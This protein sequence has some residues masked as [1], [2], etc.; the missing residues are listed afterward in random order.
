MNA[1]IKNIWRKKSWSI[2]ELLGSKSEYT[3]IIIGLIGQLENKNANVIDD[4]PKIEGI[5]NPRTWRE[6]APFLKGLG[7]VKNQNGCLYLS[8]TGEWLNKNLSLYNIASVMQDRFRVFGEILYILD[9]ESGTVQEVNKKICDL[10]KINWNNCSNTRK[11]MDWLEVLGLIDIIGNR[12][13]I[14]TE[15]GKKA[16]QEWILFT[17]ELLDTFEEEK[18][19]YEIS[20]AP[21]E[22][23][24]ML[25]ELCDN[26][27]L[28]K[29]RCTYNLWSP[30]PNKIENLRKILKYSC[31]K[32]ER[33]ELFKY[34][35]DE[36]NLKISS[37]ESMMPFLK[38]AGLLEEVGR[39]IYVT[40]P[41]AKEWC[42]TGAD[43]DFIRILHCHFRFVGEMLI[44]AVNDVTRN[45][46][47]QEAKYYGLN[48]EKARWIAGFLVEA[49]LLEEPQYLHLKTSTFGV[50][51]ARSLPLA[52]KTL[53]YTE[54][55]SQKKVVDQIKG[56]FEE[57][58]L[59]EKLSAAAVDPLAE[60]KGSG[61]AFEEEIARVF[62]YMGFEAKRIGGTGNTDVV[63]RW[64]DEDG[65]NTIGIVD[66]KSKSN[67]QVTHNDVSDVALDA[68][69]EKNNADYVVIIG[70]G[71]SGGTIKKFALKK[72]VSLI[73]VKE[74]IDIAKNVKKLGLNSQEIALLFQAPDGV[75]KLEDLI[76]IKQ[77]EQNLISLI[78]STFRKEQDMLDGISARDM[79][80]LLRMTDNSPSLEEILH[81]FLLLSTDEINVL[82]IYKKSSAEENTTYTMKNANATVNR[83]KMVASAI[84]L[85][86]EK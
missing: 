60:G 16:L 17:P 10:Y 21:I 29:E 83:L 28:H 78:V 39:N 55:G 86:L 63:V 61:V 32:V 51:F 52:D 12:K 20:K 1:D 84:E 50:E 66:A 72:K 15:N 8:E 68:H 31:E 11:R 76:A 38:A 27:L 43:I 57:D 62:R 45:E 48:N 81:M 18:V 64:A 53:Y 77:R 73:T 30:S 24:N 56:D 2:P 54:S 82:K 13:W 9:S 67:G 34:I 58:E 71:F 46:I 5:L 42:T 69:K 26:K 3:K 22:I 49:G 33:T 37:V 14:V 44:F 7:I 4:F 47:Y 23:E 25:Q 19:T 65:K 59:F 79:F 6:Y 36:F 41:V 70:A 85:G 35:G 40:T 80:L 74:L 75:S